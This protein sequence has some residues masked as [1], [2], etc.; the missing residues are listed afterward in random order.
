MKIDLTK[1]TDPSFLKQLSPKELVELAEQ[2]RSFLIE[3]ISKTGGHLASN[4]GVV[5][6]TLGLH[7]V[8]D[9]P[10]DTI[11]FDVSH[12]V[13]T[14]KIL[15][16][17][18]DQFNQL[19]Q[20]GGLSGYACYQE[21]IHDKWESGHAGTSI[22]AM[23]G[24]L[25]ANELKNKTGHVV[26][27]VGDASIINGTNMEALNFLGQD[28]SHRGIIVLNDNNMSIS[29]S[30]GAFSIFLSKLRGSRLNHR[31]RK[32]FDKILPNIIWRMFRRI[33]RALK[34]IF[35]TGNMFED[36]GYIYIGPIDGNNIKKVIK[37]LEM[38]KRMRGNILLHVITQKG[39][40]YEFAEQDDEGSYHGV[41]AFDKDSGLELNENGSKITWSE[42]IANI[43]EELAE[44]KDLFVVMPAML[45]G[46]GF[47]RFQEKY[48]KR[49]VDVGIAE[50]HAAVM[51]AAMALNNVNVFLPLYSTFSQR[52]YDQIL[53]DIARPN[54]K[55]IIGID[56]AGFVGEDGSTHQGL[57]DIS[58]FLSMPNMTVTMPRNLL[59]AKGILKYAYQQ[60]GPFVIRY[61]RGVTTIEDT[62]DVEVIK[63][64]WE[65]LTNKNGNYII[66]YGPIVDQIVKLVEQE[67]MAVSVI[68]ARYI[69]PVDEDLL[70]TILDSGKALLVYEQTHAS[71]SLYQKILDF[72]A[73][74]N[75][76]NKIRALNVY[77]RVIKHGTIK[78]NM[79][80]AQVAKA[81]IIKALKEL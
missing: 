12:Q 7:Y 64:S 22:S 66:A 28:K 24:Y 9:S 44:E 57:Y 2:I 21:S 42:G 55:V 47:L 14:H 43:I 40:G 72:M 69:N 76:T 3:K 67:K 80:D 4:L 63:P 35:Q 70:R 52:A 17:R 25:Y 29:K 51:S 5:E 6:L 30:V 54:L 18:A 78:D 26:G 75:Y 38:A 68:N 16:G 46:G 37:T 1:I 23:V 32:I 65:Q 59:E 56:R 36:M 19:R 39:K 33:K 11:I 58:M 74:N 53:N 79:K 49:I 77:N 31:L 27:V 60:N 50:E 34:A 20:H 45:V 71:G 8:F 10:Q 61:L 48:P 62:K 41:P 13:Y 73:Q 81:D 15:T